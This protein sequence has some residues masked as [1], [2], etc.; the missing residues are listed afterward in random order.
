MLKNNRKLECC[1]FF[2]SCFPNNRWDCKTCHT[3]YHDILTSHKLK[4]FF[5]KYSLSWLYQRTRGCCLPWLTLRYCSIFDN[6]W[7]KWSKLIAEL[8]AHLLSHTAV[9]SLWRLLW[10]CSSGNSGLPNGPLS[11]TEKEDIRIL[12]LHS[13]QY[14]WPWFTPSPSPQYHWP[15]FTPSPS[16]N[17]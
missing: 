5:L 12:I 10:N 8:P 3:N 4:M 11:F 14:H 16:H 13:Q 6:L 17:H 1:W 7:G 9:C 15:W 2:T